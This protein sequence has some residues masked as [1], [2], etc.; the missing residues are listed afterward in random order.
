MVP[1]GSCHQGR[2]WIH[3]NIVFGRGIELNGRR[4]KEGFD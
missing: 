4:G 3:S 2:F 1:S